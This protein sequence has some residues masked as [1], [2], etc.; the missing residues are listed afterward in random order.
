MIMR[1]DTT[2]WHHNVSPPP[3]ATDMST[4]A[5]NQRFSVSPGHV[6]LPELPM[7]AT[8]RIAVSKYL[9]TLYGINWYVVQQLKYLP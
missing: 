9:C 6:G 4:S 7:P 3:P 1:V 8:N 5:D 2:S